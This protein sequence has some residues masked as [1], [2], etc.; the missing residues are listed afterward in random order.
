MKATHKYLTENGQ[1]LIDIC[2]AL[3]IVILSFSTALPNLLLI[4]LG[5]LVLFNFRNFKWVKSIPLLLI[6]ISFL[7]LIVLGAFHPNFWNASGLYSRYL[8]VP[9]LFLLFSQVK[10]KKYCEYGLVFGVFVVMLVSAIQVIKYTLE[11]PGFLLDVGAIVNDLLLLDRPYFGFLL[12]LTVFICLKNAEKSKRKYDYYLLSILFA[13][14]SIYISA[15]LSIVLICLLFFIFLFKNKEVH[16]KIKIWLGLGMVLLFAV[17][18]GLSDNLVSRMH[19]END[20]NRTVHLVKDKEPR[21]VIWPCAIK[22]SQE[23]MNL[24]TGWMNPKTVENELVGCYR[25]SIVNRPDK[26]SYYLSAR[27]NTHN[28]FLGFFLL[29]GIIP[30]LLLIGMFFFAFV[31]NK[32]SF[33]LKLLFLLFLAFFLVENVFYRQLGC[34]LFGIFV[35]LYS[36]QNK[37]LG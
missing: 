32:N 30:L 17:F 10:N 8:L 29:G 26:Q 15:R 18:M 20:W 7:F 13:A 27:F 9:L 31:S 24:L 16:R 12:T 6:S 5:I 4:P 22:I 1:N 25:E 2:A 21:I 36:N 35:A 37:Q 23:K 33:E 34:Y 28:Q 14:F 19:L 3:I 11:N